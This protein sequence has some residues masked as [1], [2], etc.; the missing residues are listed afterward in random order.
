MGKEKKNQ[1]QFIVKINTINKSLATLIQKT[2]KQIF[3]I[4]YL[5]F[6]QNE[7]QDTTSECL[8]TKRMGKEI[9][10]TTL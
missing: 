2:N 5:V 8:D 9:L 3:S 10:Q 7:R 4:Q 1:S 6:I